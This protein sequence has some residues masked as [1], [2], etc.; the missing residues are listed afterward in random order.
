MTTELIMNSRPAYGFNV[1][2]KFEAW[3]L[4]DGKPI[5]FMNLMEKDYYEGF[6]C[7]CTIETRAGY[8]RQGYAKKMIALVE[9]KLGQKLASSDGFTPEG[10]AAICGK[11]P[12][13]PLY[14][15]PSRPNYDSMTFVKDWDK[16]HGPR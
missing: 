7:L 2:A 9:E 12:M 16:M 10:F 3:L 15:A 8:Q 4:V 1:L 5:V 13:L 6:V 11:I 14:E